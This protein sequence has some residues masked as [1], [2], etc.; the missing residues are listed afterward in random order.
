MK[1]TTFYNGVEGTKTTILYNGEEGTA[2]LSMVK[3]K[4]YDVDI[5]KLTQ[6]LIFDEDFRDA[7]LDT[8]D[9]DTYEE[10]E[11]L[12]NDDNVRRSLLLM[13][14]HEIINNSRKY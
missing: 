5:H 6:S 8:L 11:E 10:A 7:I 2:K 12:F 14:A 1:T 3:E 13:V 4:N 9:L